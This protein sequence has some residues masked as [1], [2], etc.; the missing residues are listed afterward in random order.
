[1]SRPTPDGTQR[2][3]ANRRSVRRR[4]LG[5]LLALP[6]VLAAG[7]GLV[8]G[9]RGDAAAPAVTTDSTLRATWID[10]DGDGALERG[11]GEP[12]RD[13]TDLAPAAR[14][15]R[16]LATL[17]Q[18]TDT[19]VRDE[20][21]PA[22]VSFLDRLGGPFTPT[23]RPQETLT[24]QAFAAG[25]RT[26]DRERPDLLL[27][28][29]DIT[30]NGTRAEYDQALAVLR[31]GARVDPDTGAPG[32]EG[33][34]EATNPDPAYYRPDVDPPVER[35]LLARA[36]A[37]FTAPRRR[38]PW[39]P[40]PGNHDLL[41]AGEVAPSAA[42]NAIAVGSQALI[43][44]R[45]GL[46]VPRDPRGASAVVEALV[47]G[48]ELPGET[49]QVTPDPRRRFLTPAEGRARLRAASALAR[50]PADPAAPGLS[51]V[52]DVGDRVRVVTL[53]F[54]Q[55]GE[56]AGGVASAAHVA[57][58]Q[59]ALRTAGTRWVLVASHQPLT[60]A[61]GGER[62]LRVLDRAPRVLAALAGDT[63]HHRVRARRSAAGGYFLVETG[64]LAD[65][66][67]QARTVRVREAQGGGAVLETWVVDTSGAGRVG[68]LADVAR[69]IAF[70]D[71]QG[72]RPGGNR[73]RR[74]DRNVRL[75]K[76]A[77]R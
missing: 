24:T 67:Q 9:A 41:A 56:G 54:D 51:A 38:A 77:P 6:A 65:F 49:A 75:F 33:P 52:R 57:F 20:E 12:L 32:Y 30:D 64:A 17:G 76:A 63:H 58:L 31:P 4:R 55:A 16:V 22:R 60:K 11:P 48:G 66:P 21:S 39:L 59:R 28:T 36:Q 3:D 19:H 1:M 26:L 23:F 70:L 42:I 10:R 40:I 50:T 47:A 72:G 5:A 14:P 13:R 15:G 27:V 2:V 43:R 8:L 69:E 74:S 53:D 62:L 37:P 7:V 73:E 29:G 45:E 68:A 18:I 25:L 34:Q 71:A 44:P 61:R 35:G 46:D